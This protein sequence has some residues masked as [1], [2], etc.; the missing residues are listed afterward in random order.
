MPTAGRSCGCRGTRSWRNRSR[1]SRRWSNARP[2]NRCRWRSGC[3]C[4][5]LSWRRRRRWGSD[6]WHGRRSSYGTRRH[7]SR[8]GR[9]RR[10]RRA[11]R[12]SCRCACRPRCNRRRGH[13]CWRTNRGRS[14]RDRCRWLRSRHTG[15]CRRGHRSQLR[16]S[17]LMWLLPLPPPLPP[18][19]GNACAP[20]RHAPGRASSSVSFSL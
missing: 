19:A 4:H 12:R 9:A 17:A 3:S 10:S 15:C 18:I 5:R 11:R 7:R 20:V 14:P 13:R 8:S 2:L 6:R 16:P 1:H